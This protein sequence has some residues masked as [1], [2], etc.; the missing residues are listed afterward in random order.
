MPWFLCTFILPLLTFWKVLVLCF[1]LFFFSLFSCLSGSLQRQRGFHNTE[2]KLGIWLWR[3]SGCWNKPFSPR[4]RWTL[5]DTLLCSFQNA[6]GTMM[7]NYKIIGSAWA[8][9]FLCCCLS[10]ILPHILVSVLSFVLYQ[11]DGL[12]YQFLILYL[13]S[14]LLSSCF[15]IIAVAMDVFTDRDIFRDIVDA[16]YKRWIPV[17]VI[18]DE[19]G[20]KLFLEMCRCLDLSDLQ[21]RVRYSMLNHYFR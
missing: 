10:Y 14:C 13:V 1:S 17:Y 4:R 7:E 8:C 16:A 2:I 21:I 3:S 19:D 18:L 5:K 11:C 15:Q 6:A 20:V 9:T 12:P